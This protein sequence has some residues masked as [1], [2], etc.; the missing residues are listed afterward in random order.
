M[1]AAILPAAQIGQLP[2]E[3]ALGSGIT[4]EARKWGLSSFL[5]SLSWH[6]VESTSVV[7][8]SYTTHPRFPSL[9]TRSG[10][11]PRLP[12]LSVLR[13]RWTHPLWVMISCGCAQKRS[14][15]EL[16]LSRATLTTITL[17]GRRFPHRVYLIKFII[18]F[19]KSYTFIK[20][21]E[22]QKWRQR[23]PLSTPYHPC[24][25]VTVS[26]PVVLSSKNWLFVSKRFSF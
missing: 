21:W 4:L 20:T 6:C 14:P 13:V 7:S 1:T 24:T 3:G 23:P 25:S 16:G 12:G 19:F 11:A 10:T 22:I 9:K 18:H 26:F 2:G 15:C 17:L 5:L 8:V